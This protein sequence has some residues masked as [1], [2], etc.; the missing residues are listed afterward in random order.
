MK[1]KR[2]DRKAGLIKEETINSWLADKPN[3]KIAHISSPTP[4]SLYIFYED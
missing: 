3:I 2:F 4:Y 1:C